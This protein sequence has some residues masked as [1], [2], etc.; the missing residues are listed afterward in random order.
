MLFRHRVLDLGVGPRIPVRGFDLEDGRAHGNV[1]VDVVRLVVRQL[2]L[3]HIVVDIRHP[4]RQLQW[5]ARGIKS[6]QVPGARCTI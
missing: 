5:N 1:L 3:G 2:E 6:S 4:D